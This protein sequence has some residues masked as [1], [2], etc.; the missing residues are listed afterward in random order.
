MEKEFP[1]YWPDAAQR[2]KFT[3]Y[4]ETLEEPALTD[5]YLCGLVYEEG[6]KVLEDGLSAKDAAAETVKKASL[7][8]AE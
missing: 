4:V 6:V 1:L 8:L 7:Y 5:E 3:A 2:Q